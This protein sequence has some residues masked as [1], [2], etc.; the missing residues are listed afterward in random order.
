MTAL[1]RIGALAALAALAACVPASEAAPPAGAYGFAIEPSPGARG[2][3]IATT[4][5]WTLR[6]EKLALQ[7]SVTAM[8]MATDRSSRNT[9][10]SPENVRFDASKS[11]SVFSRAIAAGPA[12][13]TI[14]LQGEYLDQ[15]DHSRSRDDQTEELGLPPEVSARFHA[16]ADISE[17]DNGGSVSYSG[18][19]M[20]LVLRAERSGRVVSLDLS[21]ALYSGYDQQGQGPRDVVANELVSVP[22]TVRPEVL[23]EDED[24]HQLRFDDFA[25]ADANGDGLLSA[26]ELE[27]AGCNSCVPLGMAGYVPK[28]SEQIRSRGT[29]LFV[30]R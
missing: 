1:A 23:F 27:T 12:T 25:A 19:S 16:P 2:E 7:V 6:V 26:H 18:P 9:F 17:N 20:L 5:G 28:L 8:S 22:L 30:N 13:G 24:S 11:A 10:G 15:G 4:D 14:T 3:P 21:F 29:R